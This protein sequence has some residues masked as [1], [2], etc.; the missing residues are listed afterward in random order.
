M[1]NLE[2]SYLGLHLK[3][4]LI[5]GA[6]PLPDDL[7]KVRQMEDSDVA[8][9]TMYSLFEEQISQNMVGGDSPSD[10]YGETF[11]EVVSNFSGGNL[12]EQDLEAYLT[13]LQAVKAAVEVPV[14]GSLNGVREGGWVTYAR[15]I[16]DAGADALELNLYFLPSDMEESAAVLEDRCVRI[17]RAVSDQISIPLAVKL[18]PYFT[19]LPHFA[20]RLSGSGADA[21]VLFNRFYQPDVDVESIQ[22]KPTL[23]LSLSSELRLR[24]RWLA[25][26]SSR[27]QCQLSV[28]GGVHTGIDLIKAILAGADSVQM[29]SSLLIN[30]PRQIESVLEEVRGWME[31]HEHA[32][33]DSIRGALSFSRC[34]NPEA[35]E[36][37]NYL[38]IFKSWRSGEK[39][40][41]HPPG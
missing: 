36:R 20:R 27:I 34:S 5:A 29:V 10:A 26:L 14:I 18:S 28:S 22:L 37:A 12:L 16:E 32:S 39:A 41:K 1:M 17:V 2:T 9:I 11:S 15:L 25:L 19:A 24:L 21:L 4:P 7:D 40:R 31:A 35:L 30:G 13:Q 33:L 6:S 8:A 3:N 38:R 23:D